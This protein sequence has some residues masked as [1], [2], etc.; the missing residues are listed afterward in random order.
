MFYM[1]AGRSEPM[2]MEKQYFIM[3]VKASNGQK[4]PQSL[5]QAV[6]HCLMLPQAL[7]ENGSILHGMHMMIFIIILFQILLF[8]LINLLRQDF[9]FPLRLGYFL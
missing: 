3:F 2:G 9:L 5:A 4:N 8:R 1:L 6:L 7:T